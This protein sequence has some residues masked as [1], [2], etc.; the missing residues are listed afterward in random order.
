MSPSA[1]RSASIRARSGTGILQ[2]LWPLCSRRSCRDCHCCCLAA[3]VRSIFASVFRSD[4]RGALPPEHVQ[5]LASHPQEEKRFN[6]WLVGWHERGCKFEFAKNS[7][8]GVPVRFLGSRC[9]KR[10]HENPETAGVIPHFLQIE[11]H[12]SEFFPRVVRGNP[13]LP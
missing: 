7:F 4:V 13:V 12:S 8:L 10:D 2:T 11:L 6:R 9:K 5:N 3:D 1:A